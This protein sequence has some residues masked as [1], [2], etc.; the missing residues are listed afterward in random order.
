MFI[1]YDCLNMV[2]IAI[3]TRLCKCL[4]VVDYW[5]LGREGAQLGVKI[6]LQLIFKIIWANMKLQHSVQ[7]LVY[8]LNI[9]PQLHTEHG[10]HLFGI[11]SNCKKL[12]T[13]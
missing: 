3:S 9:G 13:G 10:I 8:V 12:E 2:H 1:V 7:N 11:M 5:I 4:L 6:I